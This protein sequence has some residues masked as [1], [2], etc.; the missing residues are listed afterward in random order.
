MKPTN[1]SDKLRSLRAAKGYTQE[2]MAN[3]LQI[4][5]KTYSSW[6]NTAD[7]LP[8]TKLKSICE[9]LEI[10]IEN[11]KKEIE[12]A[13][14]ALVHAIIELRQDINHILKMLSIKELPPPQITRSKSEFY[15]NI[16]LKKGI[17]SLA[18]KAVW[19]GKFEIQIFNK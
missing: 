13:S 17:V 19:E 14:P 11:L 7:E 8:I 18:P 16:S 2:Y 4:T 10:N 12:D 9:I 1:L 15:E 5:Q 6:E 3:K